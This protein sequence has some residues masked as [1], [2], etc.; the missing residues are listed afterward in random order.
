MSDMRP[1][2][3]A[4]PTASGKSGF[5]MRLAEAL[6]G[7]IINADSMQVYR[8]LRI[9]TAR[10]GPEDEA[11]LPH[12]LYGTVGGGEGYSAGRYAQDA[13]R[14]IAQAQAA[15]RRPIIVGGTGLYFKTLVEG[16]SPIPPIPDDVRTHWRRAAQEQGA[17]IL[18]ER[19]ALRD[20]EM[21]T[22]LARTDTQRVVRALEVLDATGVSL[23][24]WQR[25]PREPV[26]D[27][28]EVVPLLVTVER[29]ELVRRIDHR[30]EQ[31]MREGG[32]EEV[33]QLKGA[34]LASDAP[35]L[36]A[37]G[38]RPLLR[39]LEGELSYADAVAAGQLET[40]QYAKRQ[41]TWSRSNMIA[42]IRISAQEMQKTRAVQA[43]FVRT[44]H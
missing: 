10:P 28:N 21:A 6:N 12:L 26:L 44:S 15:G 2:L 11:K 1:I 35:I 8:E 14:A 22:R 36:A 18:H 9:L 23:A 5:A 19:L 31:M 4:G 30:F 20:A 24:E 3:I 33:L 27:F 42:W 39:H 32:L 17:E 7:T 43:V 29:E 37:L 40:R 38:V 34:A 13:G 41:V 16:L 25:R